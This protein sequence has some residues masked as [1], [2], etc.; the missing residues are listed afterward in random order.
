MEKRLSLVGALAAACLGGALTVNS[1]GAVT[2]AIALQEDGGAVTPESSGT[3]T[4]SFSSG[5][6]TFSS[7]S[8]QGTGNPPLSGT[9]LLDTGSINVQSSA[10][11]GHT[12]K[13]FVT[14]QGN[15]AK[16][17][18]SFLSSFTSQA[19]TSGWTLQENTYVDAGNGLF[20]LTTPLSA[21]TFSG[22]GANAQV[23]SGNTGAANYSVTTVYTVTALAGPGDAN[24]T[25]D[26]AVPG[27]IVGAGL[28]GLIAA[29]SGLL[30][31]GRRRRNKADLI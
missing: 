30:A 12:L 16:G 7:V 20:A 10:A 25:I 18:T 6:G 17:L 28:P 29:C 4:T 8:V 26:V 1:A 13:V 27:P 21:F 9:S 31:L 2:V 15:T 24:G 19:L 23:A 5:F 3:G 22:L 11:V 14:S